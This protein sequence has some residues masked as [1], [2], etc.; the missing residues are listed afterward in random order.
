MLFDFS[1]FSPADGSLPVVLLWRTTPQ[2]PQFSTAFLFCLPQRKK[3]YV[4]VRLREYISSVRRD[5]FALVAYSLIK[6]ESEI[7]ERVSNRSKLAVVVQIG[8]TEANKKK[9]KTINNYSFSISHETV[10]NYRRL[11]RLKS[12]NRTQTNSAEWNRTHFNSSIVVNHKLMSWVGFEFSL[13]SRNTFS[14]V[15]LD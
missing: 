6:A 9:W 4:C 14:F 12:E 10:K 3:A 13:L 7:K 1:R 8:R 11:L 5:S 15:T 2:M